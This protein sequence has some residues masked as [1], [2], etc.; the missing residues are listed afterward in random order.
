[1]GLA[2]AGLKEDEIKQRSEKLASG[3]W[4]DFSAAER[5]AFLF[6]ARLSQKP[7]AVSDR[8]LDDLV[9]TF[10]PHR[11]LDVIWRTAWSNYMTR[12]ADAFQFP[13]EREN[14]FQPR[15]PAAEAKDKP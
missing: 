4:S 1:M 14:V 3:D 9:K 8:Q 11:A 13:L 10:G 2:V 6:A 12:V 15:A 5:Q 7:S